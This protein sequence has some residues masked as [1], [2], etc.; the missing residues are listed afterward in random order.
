MDP[1][2]VTAAVI[3]TGPPQRSHTMLPTMFLMIWIFDP[4]F[5]TPAW[6]VWAAV[7]AVLLAFLMRF[8]IEWALALVA[9]W[10][11]RTAAANQVYFAAILFFSGQMAPLSLMPDW[12]QTLAALLPFR[13][14]MAFPTELLLG[15]LTPDE[16]LWGMVVQVVWLGL[17]WGMM[18][19]VWTRGVKRYSAVGS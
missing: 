5:N 16:V 18:A 13:W 8:F 2:S 1:G 4:V 12:V 6:A 11:T 17:A 3:F 10:T 15:R 14:M 7:P 9:L 19:L